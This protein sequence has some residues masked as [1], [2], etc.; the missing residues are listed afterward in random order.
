MKRTKK[1]IR[2]IIDEL[3]SL[4]CDICPDLYNDSVVPRIKVLQE[5]MES[6]PEDFIEHVMKSHIELCKIKNMGTKE[7]Y[8]Q[9]PI[10]YY[11]AGVS[12]ESGELLNKLIRSLRNGYDEKDAVEAV[13]SELPDVYIYGAVLA[14]VCGLDIMNE[15][16]EK[17]DIVVQRVH[18]GYYGKPFATKE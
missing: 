14:Y 7:A 5:E 16:R 17:V 6:A 8:G 9:N 13:R 4:E 1:E 2:G 12:A 10:L 15:V 18:D 11:A 3:K